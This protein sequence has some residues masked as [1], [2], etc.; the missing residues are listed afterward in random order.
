MIRAQAAKKNQ[1]QLQAYEQALRKIKGILVRSP[2]LCSLNLHFRVF[3]LAGLIVCC[4]IKRRQNLN[5]EIRVRRRSSPDGD[6]T[7]RR[8]PDGPETFK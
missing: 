5:G 1:A 2:V 7:G 3:A 8:R 6:E 4:S